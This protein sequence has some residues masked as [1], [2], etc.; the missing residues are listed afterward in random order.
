MHG[1]KVRESVY[2]YQIRR[3]IFSVFLV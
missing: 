1:V 3:V 2:V